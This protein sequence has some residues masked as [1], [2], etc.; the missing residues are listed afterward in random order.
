MDRGAWWATVP[1]VAKSRT[2]LYLNTHTQAQK[3]KSLPVFC[4]LNL[5]VSH[6]ATQQ[7]KAFKDA[8]ISRGDSGN[9]KSRTSSTPCKE[10]VLEPAGRWVVT[11][12]VAVF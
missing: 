9:W 12:V 3:T 4:L 1:G 10:G 6:T 8:G 2:Q 7:R 11:I 5:Q